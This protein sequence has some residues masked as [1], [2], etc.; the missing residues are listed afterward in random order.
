MKVALLLSGGCGSRLGA[1]IPKQ[2]LEVNNRMIISYCLRAIAETVC[3]DAVQIVADPAWREK[4]FMAWEEICRE[5]LMRDGGNGA[6]SFE[7]FKGKL[8]GF[9]APGETR[10]LSILNGLEDIQSY[11]DGDAEIL[12]HDAA[13]PRITSEMITFYF[14]ALG[15]HDGV[16]P[17][18]PMKDTIYMSEDGK[19]VSEL[20]D[21]NR[22]FAGQAPEVYK[23]GS[24]LAANRALLPEKIKSICGT[25]EP[26]VLAG[27]DVLMVPGEEGNFKITTPADLER[28]RDCM[29]METR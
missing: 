10:Q 29:N 25:T 14:E 15:D 19:R 6:A 20:L 24:Y 22:L 28:F 5:V 11:A 21:R 26:A 17:V 1:E 2:Y 8:R 3:V 23:L 4:I 13:R 12:I 27:L 18:L 9:S 7:R 16:L